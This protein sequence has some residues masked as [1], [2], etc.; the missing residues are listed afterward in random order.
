MMMMMMI[1]NQSISEVSYYMPR[2]TQV[3][4]PIL[5]TTTNYYSNLL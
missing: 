5:R 4:S 1:P 3:H 2:G